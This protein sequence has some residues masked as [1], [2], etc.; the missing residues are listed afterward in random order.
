[1]AE[2]LS[3]DQI[4]TRHAWR[5]CRARMVFDSGSNEFALSISCILCQRTHIKHDFTQELYHIV[6]WTSP[7]Y[8]LSYAELLHTKR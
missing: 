1:M 8:N 3:C 4:Q 5:L 6:I 7:G 2:I